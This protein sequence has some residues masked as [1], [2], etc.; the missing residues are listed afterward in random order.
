M[1]S[2]IRFFLTVIFVT[3]FCSGS[4]SQK[5][6]AGYTDYDRG[7]HNFY[8]HKWDSAF[9]MFSR[10]IIN[11]DDTLKKGKA[12]RYMGEMLLETG[13]LYGAQENLTAAIHNL[14]PQNKDHLEDLGFVYNTLGNVSTDLKQYDEAIELYNK[15]MTFIKTA[16]YLV[17]PMN[18]KATA[19]QKKGNYQ[20]A[21]AIYD[22]GL[23]LKPVDQLLVARL[24]DNRARTKLLQNPG[25]PATSEFWSAMKIRA[26]SQFS[27]GLNASYAHLSDYY[28]KSDP[29]SALWYANKM[30]ETATANE[31]PGDI[32]EAID[33]M[34]RLNNSSLVKEQLYEAFKRLNDSLHFSRDTTRNRFALIR[35]DVQKSK[36]DNLVLQ[37]NIS[38]QRLMMYG[39]IA[40]AI[41]IFIGIY[42]LYAKRKKKIKQ[43]AENEIRN[44]RLKTS[45]K[46]HDVVANGLYGIMNE[47]EHIKSIEREPL[48]DKIEGLYEKSRNISYEDIS[49][50][51]SI[52]YDKLII[53]LP[54]SFANEQTKV[55]TVGDQQIFW[56][57]MTE[58][59][60]RELYLVLN[61]IMINMKKHSQAKNVVIV[62][63]Q[64]DNKGIINYR[65]DGVGFKDDQKF[66]NGLN[67]TVSRIKSLNGEVNFEKAESGGLS[68][69]ISIPL[70]SS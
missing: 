20:N 67:N 1:K 40:I 51:D 54:G 17:E 46:I 33:K 70:Q 42:F 62:F 44:S 34:I 10:Y 2:A 23:A 28:V 31:S 35:Y 8:Y 50:V 14:D 47:L 30:R 57:T 22:S 41:A 60:K 43:E 27:V 19:F 16:D 45:Q 53:R 25:Y 6:A 36:A 65:D 58:S 21:I 56:S 3:L 69:A 38:R 15:A 61:E 37:Q 66:G 52:D 64:E 7:Y 29:D 11:P 26:D 68:I 18:G 5:K 59:Q 4:L 63:K 48:I 13:D 39:L 55:I 32:L 12:Y 9:L 49:I 24:I